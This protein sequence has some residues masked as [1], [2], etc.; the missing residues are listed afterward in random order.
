MGRYLPRGH[1]DGG[2]EVEG[3]SLALLRRVAERQACSRRVASLDS[4]RHCDVSSRGGSPAST[5]RRQ[6]RSAEVEG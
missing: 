3:Q 2:A 5:T 4:D 1:G 6:G